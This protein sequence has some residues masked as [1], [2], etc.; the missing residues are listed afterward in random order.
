MARNKQQKQGL[1]TAATEQEWL[2]L[3]VTCFTD[4]SN[5]FSHQRNQWPKQ[6]I[7]APCSFQWLSPQG[8]MHLLPPE[9]L[10]TLLPLAPTRTQEP[11]RQP[12]QASTAVQ[13]QRA[14]LD[15]CSW[16]PP[17]PV[18][19][20]L[21]PLAVHLHVT[22]LMPVTGFYCCVWQWHSDLWKGLTA[23]EMHTDNQGLHSS[24]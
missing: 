24:L 1:P 11:H 7:Q 10:P 17:L 13:V 16:P 22:G 23:T 9:S 12:T 14:R 18:Y 6:P 4:D 21:A 2:W 19:L 3:P 20:E 5:S 15:H 8:Y